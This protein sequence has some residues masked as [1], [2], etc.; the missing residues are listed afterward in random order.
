MLIWLVIALAGV[1]R[2]WQAYR[3]YLRFDHP[4]GTVLAS[5]CVVGLFMLNL[6]FW[7]VLW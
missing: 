3:H 2:L 5:Q 1:Y 6:F 7:V 4:F